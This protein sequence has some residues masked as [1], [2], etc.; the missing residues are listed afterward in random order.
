M[1]CVRTPASVSS[2][3]MAAD[4]SC[5]MYAKMFEA[6]GGARMG[7]RAR[8]PQNGKLARTEGGDDGTKAL[9]EK[10]AG[11]ETGDID[12]RTSKKRKRD[13]AELKDVGEKMTP[14]RCEV[15]GVDDGV[16]TAEGNADGVEETPSDVI[17]KKTRKVKSKA[18]AK[19]AQEDAGNDVETRMEAGGAKRKEAEA[20][21]EGTGRAGEDKATKKS[22]LNKKPKKRQK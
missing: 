19:R 1:P 4:S 16:A 8:A 9:S 20:E 2:K 3:A 5:S 14:G 21:A 13:T 15:D 10:S 12:S 11:D 22:K 6:T 17:S 7:M 18:K